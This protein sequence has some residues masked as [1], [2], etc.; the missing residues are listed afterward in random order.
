MKAKFGPIQAGECKKQTSE[1]SGTLMTE[2]IVATTVYSGF[3]ASS[4]VTVTQSTKFGVG[5]TV[6]ISV[7]LV[8]ASIGTSVSVTTDI[9]NT[10]SSSVRKTSSSAVMS[11][12]RIKPLIGNKCV[13]KLHAESCSFTSDGSIPVLG[14][15]YVWFELKV[16]TKGRTRVAY[17]LETVLTEKQRS[18]PIP[19]TISIDTK[20]NGDFD[21]NC[22]CADSACEA[23]HSN[24]AV[25]NVGSSNSTRAD[26]ILPSTSD[27]SLL[28]S[29]NTAEPFASR[30]TGS[31]AARTHSFRHWTNETS[32]DSGDVD[33]YDDDGTTVIAS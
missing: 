33:T 7:D 24:N 1:L 15:G 11:T 17:N 8:V 21:S 10:K 32:G 25:F 27:T 6:G 13:V 14:T 31:T 28:P 5:L 26:T 20:A 2:G 19:L 12:V 18:V 16:K 30:F 9:T 29:N 23:L 22:V 4:E 3:E